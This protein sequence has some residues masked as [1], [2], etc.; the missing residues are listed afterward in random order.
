MFTTLISFLFVLSILVILHELGH[1]TVAKI[2]GIGVERFSVGYPPKLFGVKWGD[3]EYVVSAIPFGGYVKMIG[4]EDFTE[5]KGGEIGPNDYRGKSAPVRAAVLFAGSF[6]NLAAA[7]V[8]FFILFMMEG[9]PETSTKV[10]AV[11][12]GSVAEKIGI[13]SGDLIVGINGK[14]ATRMEDVLIPLYMEKRTA[15]T[16]ADP[17]GNTR[18]A[19]VTRK[20]GE[21]EDFGIVPWIVAKVGSVVSGSPAEK[22]GLLKGDVIAAID[23]QKVSGWFDM[24]R[25]IR[26]NPGKELKF[27]IRRGAETLVVPITPKLYTEPRPDG[28]KEQIGR[29]GVRIPSENRK[30]GAGEAFRQSFH[31]TWFFARSTFDFFIKLVTGRMSPKLLGGPV[32]IAEMAGESARSGFATLLSFTAFISVNLGVLNLLPFPVLD[33]GHIAIIAIETAVRRKVSLRARM[34]IQQ[35]GIIVLFLLMFYVTFNDIMRI[36]TISHFFGK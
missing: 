21:R 14:K 11:Q 15:L 24:N 18:E 32:M 35:A 3:T 5:E 29:I 19:V 30:A 17:R 9:I 1:F 23:T 27:T 4:Q 20:L 8:I 2:F 22:A 33:G 31:Q 36:D 28:S 13:V 7:V 16:L 25:I 34:A 12:P 6:M 26:S 10:G